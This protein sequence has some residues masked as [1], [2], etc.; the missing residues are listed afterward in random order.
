MNV[1]PFSKDQKYATFLNRWNSLKGNVI[2]GF[3]TK[4]G[5]VSGG[6]YSSLNLCLHVNDNCETVVKNRNLLAEHL[7]FPMTR[8]ACADQVH[9]NSIAKVTKDDAGKGVLNYDDAIK[10]TDGL[11]T[12][13]SNVLLTL[14]YADC[15]P[16]YFL[17]PD[18]NLVGVAHAGWKGTVKDIS[19]EMVRTWKNE[20]AID[21]ANIYAAI[22]PSIGS[23]CYVVD[24]YVIDF[25][26]EV[27]KQPTELPYKEVSKGQYTLDLKKLNKMLLVQA[28]VLQENIDV[29][30]YC[31]SCEDTLFFS[32]R[33]DQGKT[34]RMLSFIGM[35]ETR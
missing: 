12:N 23:C 11:Y 27:L 25:V 19:G 3:T 33:R 16:I 22:G 29:S 2:A 10:G 6:E 14:C 35:K 20:E 7:G 28:G 4:Q 18:K 30:S 32:H 21:P 9:E 24:D 17:G 34:G 13:E 26:K 15:V 5:G 1:E 8:W 31:T